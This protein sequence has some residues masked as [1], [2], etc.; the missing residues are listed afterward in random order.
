METKINERYCEPE[1]IKETKDNN[2]L[3]DDMEEDLI[4]ETEEEQLSAEPSIEPAN[5]G[6]TQIIR[7]TQDNQ[8]IKV[9]N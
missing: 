5:Y 1:K 4:Y 6:E 8:N 3:A 7:E 9:V 2:T